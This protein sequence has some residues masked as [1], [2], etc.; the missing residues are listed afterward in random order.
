MRF[1]H[2]VITRFSHR[3]DPS[4]PDADFVIQV[5]PTSSGEFDPLDPVKLELRMRL[6]SI[7][8]APCV[9]AQTSKDFTWVIVIDRELQ[10]HFRERLAAVA[11]Q[12]PRTIIHEYDP[13]ETIGSTDWLQPYI[14]EPAPDY[15]LTTNLDDDDGLP[16]RF[17]EELQRWTQERG[18]DASPLEFFGATDAWEWDLAVGRSAPLGHRAAWHRGRAPVTSCGVSLLAR[19][20]DYPVNM[21]GV[22]HWTTR[23]LLDWS[24][25]GEAGDVFDPVRFQRQRQVIERLG[26]RAGDSL[27]DYDPANTFHDTAERVG[28]PLIANHGGNAEAFRLYE[29]KKRTRVTGPE[30]FPDHEIDWEIFNRYA[31]TFRASR[32]IQAQHYLRQARFKWRRIKHAVLDRLPGRSGP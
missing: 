5:R 9:A 4:S 19:Y 14:T 13:A 7:I 29:R 3:V 6:F 15:L 18:D 27:R 24:F 11:N 31:A 8:C 16:R 1:Q 25:A 12:H 17:V 10:P 20:P 30:S 22:H 32:A 28:R 21:M 23:K 2:F 26:E